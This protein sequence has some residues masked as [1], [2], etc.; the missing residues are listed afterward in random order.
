M[1]LVPIGVRL[2]LWLQDRVNYA[3]FYRI[4][5]SFLLL[6]GAQLVYQGMAR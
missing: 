1:P 3:W 2:G 5:Q 6:T 4:T